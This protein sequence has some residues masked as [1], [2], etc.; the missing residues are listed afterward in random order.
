MAVIHTV[1]E[2][3]LCR[4]GQFEAGKRTLCVGLDYQTIK[5]TSIFWCYLGKNKKTHYEIESAEALRI[6]HQ[7][8]NPKGKTVII[9]PLN[10]FKVITSNWN[11]EEYRKKEVERAKINQDKLFGENNE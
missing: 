10:A 9:V 6:G 8:K 2:P 7:W 1:R 11:E 4:E 3:F 5:R